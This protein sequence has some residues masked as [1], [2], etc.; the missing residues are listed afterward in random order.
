MTASVSGAPVA[1]PAVVRGKAPPRWT[2]FYLKPAWHWLTTLP[3]RWTV[4]RMRPPTDGVHVWYGHERV[5]SRDEVAVGGVV[6]L[7]GLQTRFP[8]RAGCFNLA[9]FVSSRPPRSAVALARALRGR[10]VPLVWNQNGVA[11]PGWYGSRYRERNAQMAPLLHAADLVLYQSEFCRRAADVFLGAC[12]GW[13]EIVY[14]PVDVAA[15]APSP[16]HSNEPLVLLLGGAQYQFYR[17]ETAV[18]TLA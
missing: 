16:L 17:L 8:N 18:K 15:F 1:T 7:Q 6:K 13:S 11:T 14:N 3:D 10:G 2:R 12:R 5:P 4:A 9:Y